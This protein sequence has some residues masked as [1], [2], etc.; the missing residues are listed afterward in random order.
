MGTSAAYLQAAIDSGNDNKYMKDSLTYVLE[1]LN[2]NGVTMEGQGLDVLANYYS[3]GVTNDTRSHCICDPSMKIR[4][5]YQY[6]KYQIYGFNFYGHQKG[7][8][9]ADMDAVGELGASQV[10]IKSS[11]THTWLRAYTIAASDDRPA[12]VVYH[13]E[14]D[15]LDDDDNSMFPSGIIEYTDLR[16]TFI[17]WDRHNSPMTPSFI[18]YDTYLITVVATLDAIS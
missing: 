11:H 3:D 4:A 9:S 6:F 2:D 16:Y 8:W 7:S 18:P 17:Y 15:M 14:L 5:A 13:V 1:R 10:Q 12:T